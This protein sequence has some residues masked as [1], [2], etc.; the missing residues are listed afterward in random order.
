[1]TVSQ[2]QT[3]TANQDRPEWLLLLF[4]LPANQASRRVEIWRKLKK[5]GGLSFRSSGYLL[6]DTPSN[7]ERFEWLSAA[8]RKYKGKLPSPNYL[9]SMTFLLTSFDDCSSRHALKKTDEA[10]LRDIKKNKSG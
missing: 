5:Y 8:I 4:T 10:L 3:R 6:P 1:M 9:R 7:H 2:R